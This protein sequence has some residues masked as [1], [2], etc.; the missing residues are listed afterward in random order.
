MEC[1]DFY[2]HE[3]SLVHKLFKVLVPRYANYTTAF[4]SIYFLAPNYSLAANEKVKW[5]DRVATRSGPYPANYSRYA[6][7][8]RGVLELKGMQSVQ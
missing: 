4:T 2:L 7:T 3:K 1:A 8:E 6:F 5:Q